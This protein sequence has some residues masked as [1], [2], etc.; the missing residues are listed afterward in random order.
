MISDEAAG[1]IKLK[2][3]GAPEETI[4][5]Q[6]I[7]KISS[8]ALSLMPEGLEATIPLQDMA[9]LLTYLTAN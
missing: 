3:I 4:L 2:R 5:R 8:S 6:N 1:S 7:A 9:D